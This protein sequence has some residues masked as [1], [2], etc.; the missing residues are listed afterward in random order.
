MQIRSNFFGHHWKEAT[1]VLRLRDIQSLAGKQFQGEPCS[2]RIPLN[3]CTSKM[4]KE[5][6]EKECANM[7][8]I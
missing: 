4:K 5:K 2:S 1:A 7:P 6:S 8:L 3:S